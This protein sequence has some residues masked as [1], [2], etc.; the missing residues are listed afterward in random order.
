MGIH[1]FS[2]ENA[3]TFIECGLITEGREWVGIDQ[4]R[5]DKFMMLMRRYLRQVF[6]FLAK[7]NWSKINNAIE[8][9]SSSVV[10]NREAT[11]G[12][13]LHFTDI[14]LEEV[15]KA[16]GEDLEGDIVLRLIEPFA[17]EL[18]EGDDERLAK[19]IEERIYQHLMRQSDIGEESE[20]DFEEEENDEEEMF[21]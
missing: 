2:S 17:K 4:W 6:N 12:F 14:F 3:L 9:F 15:A 8:I 10:S 11:L 20:D 16:G 21:L 5:M 1:C 18:A 19:H 7:D 13:R